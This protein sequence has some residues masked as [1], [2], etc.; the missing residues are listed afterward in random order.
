MRLTVTGYKPENKQFRYLWGFYV[1]G[2]KPWE[3]CQSC[4]RGALAKEIDASLTMADGV[5]LD[6]RMDYFYLHGN[7]SGTAKDRKAN[8]LHLAVRP[9]LGATATV[10]AGEAVFT[11]EDAEAIEIQ[12]PI[13]E[14]EHLK[15]YYKCPNFR[16]G[17]QMYPT[18]FENAGPNGPHLPV[19]TSS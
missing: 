10:T 14:L 3:H 13:M 6:Q 8:N 5:D 16:F 19:L 2:F 18:P 9:K 4:F 17:M 1:R 11:I 15:M 7:A 12:G